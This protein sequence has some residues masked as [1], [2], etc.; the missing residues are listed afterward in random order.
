MNGKPLKPQNSAATWKWRKKLSHNLE[1]SAKLKSI[2][3]G[4]KE[5]NFT[6]NGSDAVCGAGGGGTHGR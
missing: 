5:K 4:L 3:P 6:V 1:N 2:M